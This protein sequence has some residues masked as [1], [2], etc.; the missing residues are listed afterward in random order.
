M[1]M[2]TEQIIEAYTAFE[3]AEPD[4]STERLLAMTAQACQCDVGDVAEALLHDQKSE[5]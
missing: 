3:D 5:P 4:I 2:T 1:N